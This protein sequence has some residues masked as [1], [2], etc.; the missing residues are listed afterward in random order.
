MAINR[1]TRS[2]Q[3][4]IFFHPANHTI[5]Y[6]NDTHKTKRSITVDKLTRKI[7]VLVCSYRDWIT[8]HDR[9]DPPYRLNRR[10]FRS[11]DTYDPWT[12]NST[13]KMHVHAEFRRDRSA[14]RCKDR[15]D[16]V[17]VRG[18]N[19]VLCIGWFWW[20][21]CCDESCLFEKGDWK[22][23]GYVMSCGFFYVG[24]VDVVVLFRFCMIYFCLIQHSIRT[25]VIYK[26]IVIVSIFKISEYLCIA[27]S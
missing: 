2:I 5:L 18:D 27:I 12:Q 6:Y 20:I 4:I 17:R 21:C 7:R 15:G 14:N 26:V 13:W 22:S 10:R 16:M 25:K 9:A 11:F 19:E 3:Y 8:I 23:R 24:K 1:R